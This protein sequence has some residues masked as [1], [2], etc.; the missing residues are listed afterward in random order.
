MMEQ[1][2]N[3]DTAKLKKV[4]EDIFAGGKSVAEQFDASLYTNEELDYILDEMTKQS[5]QD[6]EGLLKLVE[7]YDEGEDEGAEG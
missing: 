6:V 2:D 5:I 1:P 4:V 3:L 7:E